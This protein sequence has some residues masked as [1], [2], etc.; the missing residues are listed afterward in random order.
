MD[1]VSLNV[2]VGFERQPEEIK[3][4]FLKGEAKE[5][6]IPAL[7][8]GF[9]YFYLYQF[10]DSQQLVDISSPYGHKSSQQRGKLSVIQIQDPFIKHMV[11]NKGMIN[12]PANYVM[13]KQQFRSCLD[14]VFKHSLGED[15]KYDLEKQ[16][17]KPIQE[18]VDQEISELNRQD[19]Q[20]HETR[21]RDHEERGRQDR[22]KKQG[23]AH[24]MRKVN[25]DAKFL[26]GR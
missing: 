18:E 21:K 7:L 25:K 11:L 16:V 12:Q 26:K 10:D 17:L 5:E 4:L 24:K 3:K 19:L 8:C 6:S 2:D 9:F 20:A 22:A 15:A 14:N 13:M 23:E 1:K